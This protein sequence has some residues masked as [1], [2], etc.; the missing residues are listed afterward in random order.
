MLR[1]LKKGTSAIH[2][3][4]GLLNHLVISSRCL[5]DSSLKPASKT[6]RPP[7]TTC[8]S[9][10]HLYHFKVISLHFSATPFFLFFKR[11]LCC[12]AHPPY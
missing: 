7:Q 2:P 10:N 5:F 9:P 1:P 11:M 4:L 8:C 6:A 3:L 12:S